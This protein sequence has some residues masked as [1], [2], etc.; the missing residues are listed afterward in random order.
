[1]KIWVINQNLIK[2]INKHS[3]FLDDQRNSFRL[4]FAI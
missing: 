2:Q 3:M 1:M 4:I